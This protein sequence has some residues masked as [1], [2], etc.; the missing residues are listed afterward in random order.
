MTLPRPRRD[1]ANHEFQIIKYNILNA[2][3]FATGTTLALTA[4]G[5]AVLALVAIFEYV[6]DGQFQGRLFLLWLASLLVG[7][8]A[9]KVVSKR[10][11]N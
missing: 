1:S 7:P 2:I 3:S 9:A 10:V 5:V 6:P 4:S 8:I 11:R